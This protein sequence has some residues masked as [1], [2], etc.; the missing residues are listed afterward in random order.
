MRQNNNP[1]PRQPQI[2]LDAMAPRLDG[3]HECRQ[4]VL[5]VF[6]FVTS[7]GDG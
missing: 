5:G 7:V 1:V 6:P 3:T 2:R 4:A